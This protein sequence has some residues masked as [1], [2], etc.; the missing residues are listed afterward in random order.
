MS[1]RTGGRA[2]CKYYD[3]CGTRQ[4]CARCKGYKKRTQAPR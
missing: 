1:Q 3:A 4:N 2:S